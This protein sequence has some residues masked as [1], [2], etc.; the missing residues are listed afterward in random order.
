MT[1][2]R[3]LQRALL[4]WA[5]DHVSEPDLP[6]KEMLAWV[7]AHRFT[8]GTQAATV[9]EKLARIIELVPAALADDRK[10]TGHLMN[11]VESLRAQLAEPAPLKADAIAPRSEA[12]PTARFHRDWDALANPEM[13]RLGFTRIKGTVSRW[14]KPVGQRWLHVGFHPSKR[15]WARHSGSSFFVAV[16]LSAADDP[17]AVDSRDGV[18]V[19]SAYSDAEFAPFLALNERAS[20]TVR[21]LSF[22]DEFTRRQHEI[23]LLSPSRRANKRVP[24]DMTPDFEFYDPSELADWAQ[25]LMPTLGAKL[26]QAIAAGS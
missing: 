21:R 15:G 18:H 14:R 1:V 24:G 16:E 13:T 19:F 23:L 25:A 2:L 10:Y 20:D 17:A 9:V 5:A 3:T 26:E 4:H 8:L 12:Y 22:A 7:A 11:S 6:M